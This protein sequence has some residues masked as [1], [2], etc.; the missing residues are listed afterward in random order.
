[1]IKTSHEFRDP[2]H[3]FILCS[4]LE[5][6]A[7]DSPPVQRLRHITQ[8]ATTYLVYPGTT[9]KRFEHSLGTMHIASEI[10]DIL[11]K[12]EHISLLPNETLQSMPDFLDDKEY[13]RKIL[14]MAALLHDV[15]HMPFSHGAEELLPDG[16]N[17]ERLTWD[18]IHSDHLS[19]IFDDMHIKP[20]HVAKIAI[21]KKE[22]SEFRPDVEFTTWESIL[23]EIV[24]GEVF[25]A[26]RIDYL[27]RDSYHAGVRYGFFD[28]K[29]LINSL[30]ILQAPPEGEDDDDRSWAP[31]IGIERGGLHVAAS[32][33]WAR[34]SMFS[35]V[36]F[37]HVRRAYDLHLKEFMHALF[38]QGIPVE[39]NDYLAI[40]DNEILVELRK[41][42][43]NTTAAG[44]E[45]AKRIESRGHFRLAH[46]VTAVEL[47]KSPE[48]LKQIYEKTA[49]KFG[50]DFVRMDPGQ[51]RSND[52]DFPVLIDDERSTISA[53]AELPSI[54]PPD[55]RNPYI[56]VAPE[57]LRDAKKWLRENHDHLV[58]P[59]LPEGTA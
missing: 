24:T 57:K 1:M 52:V 55:V 36:Y 21:G 20:V 33:L 10:F 31:A 47:K 53:R 15:G 50:E 39:I 18:I 38:P 59:W 5:R 35:Q 48:A 28:Y 40:A 29:R 26:D 45:P 58:E 3:T 12:D 4:S 23:S 44:H 8:L 13:W 2:I 46:Q 17:H 34:Y 56:F 14:R 16:Y 6:K 51:K 11:T 9:H 42:A 25:G 41:A 49:K 54:R 27:L 7:I 22:V 30:R 19:S 43:Y 37:H 32:L